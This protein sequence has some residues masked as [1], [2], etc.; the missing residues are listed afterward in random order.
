[1]EDPERQIRSRQSPKAKAKK[2]KAKVT[3]AGKSAYNPQETYTTLPTGELPP[4]KPSSQPRK[5][6]L[7][8]TPAR[9]TPEGGFTEGQSHRRNQKRINEADEE[10]RTT[11]ARDLKTPIADSNDHVDA[12]IDTAIRERRPLRADQAFPEAPVKVQPVAHEPVRHRSAPTTVMAPVMGSAAHSNNVR[13]LPDHV[14][15][16]MG[17]TAPPRTDDGTEAPEAGAYLQGGERVSDPI[18]ASEDLAPAGRMRYVE[19]NHPGYADEYKM[20]LLHRL[21][22]RGLPLDTIARMLEITPRSVQQLRVRLFA[23]LRVEAKNADIY[24][25]AGQTM[26]FYREVRSVAMRLATENKSGVQNQINA[27]RVALSAEA[28]QHRFLQASGFYE[29]AKY[30]P[31]VDTSDDTSKTEGADVI[32]MVMNMMRPAD[33]RDDPDYE[34]DTVDG[35]TGE[36]DLT[37]DETHL[38]FGVPAKGAR[39]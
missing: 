9:Y 19:N 17:R 21:L 18:P 38:L 34:G 24:S 30:M 28:D 7:V 15:Q 13:T 12:E 16:A 5:K 4:P 11:M 20:Q 10:R 35:L 37:E 3:D 22:L 2:P 8:K 14:R 33:R 6:P 32:D 25:I 23:R 26:A 39:G 1:M 27:L 29:Q 31:A 36:V